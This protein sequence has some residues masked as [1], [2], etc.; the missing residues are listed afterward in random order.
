MDV[1]D[2]QRRR[3][4]EEAVGILRVGLGW[5]GVVVVVAERKG[6][7]ARPLGRTDQAAGALS[8]RKQLGT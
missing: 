1:F 3:G 2:L 8:Q 5:G 4:G 6:W 7:Q